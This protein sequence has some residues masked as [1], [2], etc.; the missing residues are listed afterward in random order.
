MDKMIAGIE[1]SAVIVAFVTKAY[2]EKVESEREVRL[3][4]F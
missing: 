3:S 2:I 4:S 1:G